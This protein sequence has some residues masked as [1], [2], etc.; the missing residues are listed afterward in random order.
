MNCQLG[1]NS[2][3]FGLVL[4]EQEKIITSM[5]FQKFSRNDERRLSIISRNKEKKK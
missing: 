1:M 2:C 5:A 3:V 4:H